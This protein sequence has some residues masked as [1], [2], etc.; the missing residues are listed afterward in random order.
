MY[1]PC[2]W[3][4]YKKRMRLIRM[5]EVNLEHKR[6]LRNYRILWSMIS[7]KSYS[8]FYSSFWCGYCKSKQTLRILLPRSH[9]KHWKFVNIW[10]AY[11]FTLFGVG[12]QWKYEIDSCVTYHN[13][14]KLLDLTVQNLI[15]N[16][17]GSVF[18]AF[19]ITQRLHLTRNNAKGQS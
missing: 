1:F 14:F 3:E 16:I 17:N 10:G 4:G 13:T 12:C 5:C 11:W 7:N 9:W 6:L 8:E 18:Y 19:G 2:E 15:Q